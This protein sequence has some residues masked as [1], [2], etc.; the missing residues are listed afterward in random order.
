VND[1]IQRISW[2]GTFVICA[3]HLQKSPFAVVLHQQ[4]TIFYR[5]KEMILWCSLIFVSPKHFR[6]K[7]FL[8]STIACTV[9]E[10]AEK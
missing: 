7:T 8:L 1:L 10:G 4:A 6:K 2:S 3:C 5:Q 9:F